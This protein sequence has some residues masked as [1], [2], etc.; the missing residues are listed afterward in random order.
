MKQRAI[1]FFSPLSLHTTINV[2]KTASGHLLRTTIMLRK[3]NNTLSGGDGTK[4]KCYI[5]SCGTVDKSKYATG[6]IQ[7]KA[8]QSIYMHSGARRQKKERQKKV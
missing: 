4:R 1:F 7:T 5:A 2:A 3:K 8:T 6:L